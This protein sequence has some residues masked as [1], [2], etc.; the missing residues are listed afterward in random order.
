MLTN[1]TSTLQII[2][3]WFSDRFVTGGTTKNI[4]TMA[5]FLTL[6]YLYEKSR[7]QTYLPWLDSW[8]EWVIN[9]LPRTEYGGMQH[10]TYDTE[11]KQ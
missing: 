9:D 4:N 10:T 1:D 11:N 2:E 7:N 3:N 5:A 6:A 8:A